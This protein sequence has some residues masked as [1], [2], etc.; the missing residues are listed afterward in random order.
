MYSK[1]VAG[2]AVP[3]GTERGGV[4]LFS[5]MPAVERR[6]RRCAR[7]VL[8]GP[9]AALAMEAGAGALVFE[10]LQDFPPGRKKQKAD[11]DGNAG[12]AA[13]LV[14]RAGSALARGVVIGRSR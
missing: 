7:F 2:A 6:E 13:F 10:S 14:R 3:V 5:F 8:K 1:C 12:A 11:E 4:F 9:M